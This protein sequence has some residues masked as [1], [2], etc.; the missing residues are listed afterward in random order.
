MT[1]ITKEVAMDCAYIAGIFRNKCEYFTGWHFSICKE[2][3]ADCLKADIE[4][5]VLLGEA[6]VAPTWS[7]YR[8]TLEQKLL[9]KSS[10]SDVELG[11]MWY[12]DELYIAPQRVIDS[13]FQYKRIAETPP[14][15][16]TCGQCGYKP[17]FNYSPTCAGTRNDGKFC[18]Q[19]VSEW[20]DFCHI[21]KGG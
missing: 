11:K 12:D 8:D 10:P 6:V 20:G 21:H 3:V 13:L 2:L 14:P 4:Y 18:R 7:N 5:D 19:Q 9:K 17:N 1:E 16:K 15:P